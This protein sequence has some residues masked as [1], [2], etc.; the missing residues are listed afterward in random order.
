MKRI[1]SVFCIVSICFAVTIL[2]ACQS[3]T[4]GQQESTTPDSSSTPPETSLPY[5]RDNEKYP[6]STGLASECDV[7]ELGISVGGVIVEG[8]QYKGDGYL[9]SGF[10]E[11]SGQPIYSPMCDNISPELDRMTEIPD[12]CPVVLY[13][14]GLK[15]INNTDMSLGAKYYYAFDQLADGSH[16]LSAPPTEPGMYWLMI[17]VD[18]HDHPTASADVVPVAGQTYFTSYRYLFALSVE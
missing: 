6:L 12:G 3:Y 15:I 8:K 5:V 11:M 4:P 10:D 18:S 2:S 1:A 7:K 9:C 16:I 13:M 14:E 17:T